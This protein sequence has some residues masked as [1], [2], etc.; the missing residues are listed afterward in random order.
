MYYQWPENKKNFVKG[1]F[2]ASNPITYFETNT[3][4]TSGIKVLLFD[5]QGDTYFAR[6]NIEINLGKYSIINLGDYN[7]AIILDEKAWNKPREGLVAVKVGQCL[8]FDSNI[9]SLLPKL[10]RDSNNRDQE[11]LTLMKYIKQKNVSVNCSP[12]L[13]EDSLN[14]SGMKNNEKAYVTLL[15]YSIFNRLSENELNDDLEYF[16]PDSEDYFSADQVWHE[17]INLRY[18]FTKREK[19]AKSIYCFLLKVYSINFATKKN[20]NSKML[21]LTGFINEQL[22]AYF[23]YGMLLAYLYFDHDKRV[24]DFFGKIQLNSTDVLSKIEGMAWDLF[25][26]WDMPS[27]M[28]A[29]SDSNNAIVLQSLVT[30][31][32]A[33]ANITKLNPIIRMVFYD[34]EAQV[35]YRYSLHDVNCDEKIIDEIGNHTKNRET[36]C[37]DID[38][39]YLS[40]KLE[41]EFINILNQY[42]NKC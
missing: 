22:G 21:Q 18:N 7:K 6:N 42:Q 35:K 27:E 28:A 16:R 24:T 9:I 8:N 1:L 12:Y 11:L 41:G 23:E 17:M 29:L 33:L 19:R 10:F 5:G 39:N 25:H 36:I 40:K 14:R 37:V 13:F 20:A 30:R 15:Y 3:N 34:E 31:D 4:E 32:V 2:M 26:I 38:L